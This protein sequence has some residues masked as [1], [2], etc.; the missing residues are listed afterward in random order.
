[1]WA[2]LPALVGA[3]APSASSPFSVRATYELLMEDFDDHSHRLTSV[4][5][6]DDGTMYTLEDDSVPQS[7]QSGDKQVLTLEP[8][9]D[10][11]YR[12]ISSAAPLQRSAPAEAQYSSRSA[13]SMAASYLPPDERSLLVMRVVYD[14]GEPSCTRECIERGLWEMQSLSGGAVQGSMTDLFSNN[15][16]GYTTFPR[17]LTCRWAGRCPLRR[18]AVPTRP[19]S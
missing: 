4:C 2:L 17:E 1:M 15:S 8:L 10:G 9:K 11:I 5:I 13:A 6:T 12:V 14:N 19:R 7:L 18:P 3:P 16:Y